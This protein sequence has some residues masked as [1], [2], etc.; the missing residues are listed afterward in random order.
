MQQWRRVKFGAQFLLLASLT[1]LLVGFRNETAAAERIEN[2]ITA[3]VGHEHSNALNPHTDMRAAMSASPDESLKDDEH[4]AFLRLAPRQQATAI[5]QHSGRWLDAR[6]WANGKLPTHH[7]RVLIP[8]GVS[9]LLDGQIEHA[10]LEWIHVE[11]QLAFAPNT[12]T[13]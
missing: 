4:Q 10:S 13:L 1:F 12:S 8:A 9:V 11:G 3:A 6:I 2:V 5:A 7:D